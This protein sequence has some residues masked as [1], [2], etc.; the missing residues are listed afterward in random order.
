[1]SEQSIVQLANFINGEWVPASNGEMM[2]IVNPA[3]GKVSAQVAKSTE[4]EAILAVTGAK[5][6]FKSGVWSKMPMN[7]RASILKSFAGL[8]QQHADEIVYLEGISSGGTLRKLGGDIYTIVFNLLQ[9]IEMAQ[10]V[11]LV[12]KLPINAAMGGSNNDVVKEPL[13]VVAAITPWN[14]PLMLAMWKIAPALIMGN[15]VIVKPASQTPL[16]TLKLAELA[17]KAGVPAGVFNVVA[18]PGKAVGDTLVKHPDVRKVTFTGSTE[19][20]R[21]IMKQG[22][23]TIK[24]VTLEL[25]GKS[26]AIVMP[27]ADLELA[28][29]GIIFGSMYNSGQACESG[30]R[31][32]VHRSIYEDVL[33]KLAVQAQKIKVGYPMLQETGMGPVVSKN[34]FDSVMGYIQAGIDEGARLITGGKAAVVE[35]S[36]G[37]YYIEPTI[38]A[39]VTNDMKIAREEIFGPVL[40]ILKYETTEEAIEIA[41]DSIYGLAGGV[42]SR[43]IEEAQRIANELQAGTIWINDWHAFRNDAPFGGYKQS[44]IGRELG[45]QIFAEYTETKHIHTSLVNEGYLR[46]APAMLF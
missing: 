12:E 5:E 40:S 17:H 1:M 26:A 32:L 2:D 18:G 39:D 24:R 8:I 21:T 29:P 34:Q 37:G 22:A 9:T 43:N 31:V 44:G 13:G 35:G 10:E 38:F 28:I 45:K 14:F 3:D 46:F 33:E 7:E 41:N 23:D 19:V 36:E 25:G 16:G 15:S 6:A 4:K 42:W 30:T 27:D 11:E 20:G